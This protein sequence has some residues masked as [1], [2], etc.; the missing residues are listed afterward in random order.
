MNTTA[1]KKIFLFFLL[2]IVF[3]IPQISTATEI[4]IQKGDI[5]YEGSFRAPDVATYLTYATGIIAFN[6]KNNSLF[7]VGSP[8]RPTSTEN[9]YVAEIKIPDNIA[10]SSNIADLPRATIIQN[11]ADITEGNRLN[12]LTD[13]SLQVSTGALGARIGGLLVNGDNLIG[14]VYAVYDAS[15]SATRS[16]F[17]TSTNLS[18]TG[19]FKGNFFVGEKPS[20]V[21]QAGYIAGYMTNIPEEW[22]TQL[23]GDILTGQSN[24]SIV[25]R[26]SYGPSAFAATAKDILIH[27]DTNATINNIYPLV[28]YA[29]GYH[30]LGEWDPTVP[31]NENISISDN[32]SGVIFPNGR[33][34]ILFIG[35][36][37]AQNCYGLGT[38]NPD[39]AGNIAGEPCEGGIL[40]GDNKCCLDPF[41]I[42]IKGPHGYPKKA[43]IWAYKAEDFAAVKNKTKAPHQITPYA[44]WELAIPTQ[45]W[46]GTD[47]AEIRIGGAAY[48]H[49]TNRIYVTQILIDGET[50]RRPIVHVYKI[51]PA[52]SPTIKTIQPAL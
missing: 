45:T 28:Y 35:D 11:F 32:I 1:A 6:D 33:N 7:M 17:T 47:A 50:S 34:T 46:D 19:D 39:E 5:E 41:N 20:V 52:Q 14:T 22:R 13:I 43:W 44:T 10:K 3:T 23:G 51:N 40:T 48:D 26:T 4:H 31:S 18:L 9:N 24:I 30:T 12:I 49:V 8:S 36:H 2:D 16:H 29:P 38:S 27:T 15:S 25:S 37:G 21:P 42:T